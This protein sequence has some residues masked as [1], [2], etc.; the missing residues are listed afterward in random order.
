MSHYHDS[1]DLKILGEF[2]KLAPAERKRRI[3][4]VIGSMEE[5]TTGVNR[6]RAMERDGVLRWA[7]YSG[8]AGKVTRAISIGGRSRV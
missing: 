7:D 3:G 8:E 6:L 2:Q 1:D 5:T 4:Q